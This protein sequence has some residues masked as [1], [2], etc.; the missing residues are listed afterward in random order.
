[1]TSIGDLAFYHCQATIKLPDSLV[2]IGNSAFAGC[3]GLTAVSIPSNVVSIGNNAFLGCTNINSL[4]FDNSGDLQIIG[5]NAF[6]SCSSLQSITIPESV[7][8]IGN[9][10]LQSCTAMTWISV[11]AGNQYYT[12]VNGVLYN[13]AI[14][15]LIQYPLAKTGSFTV[16]SSVTSI[17]SYAF[18]SSTGLTGVIIPI[19]VNAIGDSAFSSCPSLTRME[20]KG[21][22]P[23]TLGSN[24]ITNH[25]GLS[26]YYHYGAAGFTTPTWQGVNSVPVFDLAMSSNFGTTTAGG[27]Y[28]RGTTVTI[29]A[30]APTANPGE[31]YVWNGWI[32]TGAGSITGGDSTVTITMNAEITEEASWTEQYQVSF[33]VTPA[34]AGT[35]TV[36]NW[37]DAGTLPIQATASPGYAFSTWTSDNSAI[38]FGTQSQS[39][40]ANIGGP[41]TITATFTLKPVSVTIA[42]DP[43][44]SGYV[45]V[46]GSATS[47]PATFSWVPGTSHTLE[48]L[49]TVTVQGGEQYLFSTWSDGGLRA[50]TYTA[51]MSAA[52]ITADFNHQYQVTMATNGGTTVP[53][54]GS[55][56]YFA[57]TKIS[58][59]AS[60]PASGTGYQYVWN[61]WTGTGAGSYT[62]GQQFA[63][64]AVTVNGIITETANWTKQYQVTFVATPSGTGTTSP[65]PGTGW[66][67]AGSLPIQASPT[68][69][70]AFSS[71]AS[72]SGAI[73]FGSQSAST[74]A[75][76]TGAGKITASFTILPVSVTITSNPAGTGY[77]MVDGIATATPVTFTNW[78]PGDTHTLGAVGTIA[79]GSTEKYTFN[80]WSDGGQLTHPY[81]V[82]MSAATITANFDH[83]YLVTMATNARHDLARRWGPVVR[84]RFPDHAGCLPSAARQRG[85]VR[86]AV[87]LERLDR[88]RV[89]QL[90]RQ[91]DPFHQR[92]DGECAHH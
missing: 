20:F 13:K 4:S 9:G 52:T 38:T 21:D 79:I 5:G 18:S 1:M 87:L 58:L 16:P 45:L 51:T 28:D 24:W 3:T 40:V 60:G 11:Y 43:A 66:Y 63:S 62:G 42:S 69:G 76:I 71:W 32:G 59:D 55:G 31:R 19:G 37:Y 74:T 49:A 56:W 47:T 23:A 44:G 65:A 25:A 30:T 7:T 88:E 61:G 50:H 92:G 27:S 72:D 15:T 75:V 82:T 77:V 17:Q 78:L 6:A 46:D 68:S 70:Y 34:G 57:G 48:A 41:G 35:T 64:G 86:G 80:S 53:G 12:S 29:T 81:T 10:A 67:N 73:T 84:G 26:V 8:S 22:Q 54:A 90:Y 36:N 83:Q 91:Q 85:P 14:T 33:A 2:N 39:A 89:G